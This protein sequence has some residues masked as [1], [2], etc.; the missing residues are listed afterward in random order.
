MFIKY[1]AEINNDSIIKELKRITNLIYKLLP[2]REENID[3]EKPLETVIEE[4]A[5]MDRLL[6]DQHD[7]LFPLLSKLE[8]LFTLTNEED[9]ILFRRTIFECLNLINSIIKQCQD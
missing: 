7:N 1:N 5:G 9:F 6:I 8:G 2:N 4:L 3:W